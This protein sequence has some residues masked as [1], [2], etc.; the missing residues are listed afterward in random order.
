[1]IIIFTYIH[2]DFKR[3]SRSADSKAMF[4]SHFQ[5]HFGFFNLK[6]FHDFVSTVFLW[7]LDDL[8]QQMMFGIV[9]KIVIDGR[10]NV[11]DDTKNDGTFAR[12]TVSVLELV[13]NW[14]I[15]SD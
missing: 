4:H 8:V 9:G 14:K 11:L 15:V 6:R 12:T 10:S 7:D 2:V 5:S 13:K 3:G 1:M